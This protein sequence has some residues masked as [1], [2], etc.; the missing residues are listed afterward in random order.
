MLLGAARGWRTWLGHEG[1]FITH[2]YVILLHIFVDIF[3]ESLSSNDTS[4]HILWLVKNKITVQSIH[5]CLIARSNIQNLESYQH[6]LPEKSY[7]Q[8]LFA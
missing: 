3:G 2:G 8:N 4:K 5:S 7:D 1:L 6:G